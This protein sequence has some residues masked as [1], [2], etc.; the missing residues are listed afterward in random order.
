MFRVRFTEEAAADIERLYDSLLQHCAGEWAPA[1]RALQA[2][3]QGVALLHT[4]PFGGRRVGPD[5]AFLRELVIGFGAS[6]Y[7]VLYE[8]EN[9]NTVTVLAVR[10]QREDDYR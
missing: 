1:E 10:H 3:R 4:S 8:I 2:I 7:V 6:G 9:A 5:D